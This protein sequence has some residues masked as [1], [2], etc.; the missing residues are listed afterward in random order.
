MLERPSLD[1]LIGI[2]H[3]K[4]GFYQELRQKL[5]ELQDANQESEQRRQEISAI[6]DGITDMMMVLS[7]DMR[8]VSVNHVFRE[9]MG[10]DDPV[11]LACYELFR[12]EDRPCPECPAHKSFQ[13]GQVCRETAIFKV[14][15][16]NRQF[17]MV[18]SPIQDEGKGEPRILIFKRDVTMEKEYQAK[19][20]QAE[21]MATIGMLAAG[22]A[23]EINNPLAAI[24]GFAEGIMRRIPKLRQGE[25]EPLEAVEDYL[26]T[27]LRE[28]ERCQDIVHSL[29]T[30]SRPVSSGFSPLSLNDIVADTLKLL[31]SHLKN[32][33][34]RFTL[35]TELAYDLPL[36]YGDEPQLKQ[37][38]LNLLTNAMDALENEDGRSTEDNL[39]TIRTYADGQ[40]GAGLVVSD[41][42]CGIPTENLDKLFEPFFTTKPVG[43]GV[44]IGLSTCYG[45]VK[46]HCGE[47]LVFSEQGKG[48]RFIVRLPANPEAN[49]E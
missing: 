46:E 29:L 33:D 7:A 13:T 49:C 23:H 9:V 18:A 15:G 4:L 8:I 37:V 48:S 31:N 24:S 10:V 11:G 17:E 22:V 27:I 35:H 6:L 36:I 26:D 1:D 20:Y 30:F 5:D 45:I 21:K 32:K 19:F 39:I 42:G 16:R 38:L 41:S 14:G 34:R 44:G 2:E 25:T 47:I 43:K 3:C 40:E 12:N 28:C